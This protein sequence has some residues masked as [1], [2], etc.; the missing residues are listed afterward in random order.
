[1][2][3]VTLYTKE[4]CPYCRAARSLLMNKGVSFNDIEISNN[5]N[6]KVEMVKRSNGGHTVPQIFIGD[7]HIGGATDLMHLEEEGAL[8]HLLKN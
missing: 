1:M 4:Y 6:L 7:K 2:Q 8:D 5:E 3:N